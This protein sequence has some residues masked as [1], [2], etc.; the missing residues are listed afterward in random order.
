MKQFLTNTTFLI[1]DKKVKASALIGKG[2]YLFV[3]GRSDFQRISLNK[4][5]LNKNKILFK[6]AEKQ[7]YGWQSNTHKPLSK[8]KYKVTYNNVNY[9]MTY[10]DELEMFLNV[11]I[12]E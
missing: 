6:V 12:Q 1:D 4:K 7:R 5:L 2:E 3:N 8:G 11:V 10:L 9:F